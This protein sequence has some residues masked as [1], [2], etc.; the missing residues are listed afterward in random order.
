VEV[1]QRANLLLLSADPRDDI[2]NTRAIAAIVH[3]G[4]LIERAELDA[5]LSELDA[6]YTPV[7]EWFS[8]QAAEIL[9]NR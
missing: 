4:Q 1:G 7:R 6:L 3:D 8:P 9:Q 2:R 5:M